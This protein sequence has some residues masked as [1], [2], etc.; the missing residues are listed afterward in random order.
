M[1]LGKRS[2]A[3]VLRSEDLAAYHEAVDESEGS[4]GHFNAS[5]GVVDE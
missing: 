5:K 3:T 4:L 2:R 1:D